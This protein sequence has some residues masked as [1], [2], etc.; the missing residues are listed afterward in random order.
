M[1]KGANMTN[2]INRPVSDTKF[3]SKSIKFLQV[4]KLVFKLVRS[5][6]ECVDC[7]ELLNNIYNF[8]YPHAIDLINN[9]IDF[10]NLCT[11]AFYH[12]NLPRLNTKL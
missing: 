8:L 1:R 12:T 9:I 2:K 5:I 11:S 6:K 10:I 3:K 4:G 7:C